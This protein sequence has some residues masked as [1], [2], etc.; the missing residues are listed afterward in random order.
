MSDEAA[1]SLG[2]TLCQNTNLVELNIGCNNLQQTGAINLIKGITLTAVKTLNIAYNVI[3]EIP[4]HYLASPKSNARE[5]VNLNLSGNDLKSVKFF[6]MPNLTKFNCSHI[7]INKE[8]AKDISKFLSNCIN[9]QDLDLSYTN[10]QAT[11]GIYE[12][13]ELNVFHLEKVNISGNLIYAHAADVLAIFL[14]DNDKLKEI[15]LSCNNLQESGIKEVLKSICISN[16]TNLNISD[17][18]ITLD[19]E[20]IA[21]ILNNATKLVELDLSCNKFGADSMDCFLYTS[22]IIFENL[23][24]LTIFTNNISNGSTAIALANALTN[25]IKL[26][27]LDL[28]NNNLHAEGVSKIFSTLEVSTLTKFNFS[29]N[30]ITD[31]AADD[32]ATFLSRNKKLEILDL[33]NN[34]LQAS[35]AIKIFRT[36]LLNLTIVNISYNRITS[37][38]ADDIAAFLCHNTNLQV[39]DLSCNDLEELG[40]WNVFKVLHHTSVLFSLNISNSKVIND[41]ADKLPAVLLHNTL[42]QEIDLSYNNLSTSNIV[43]IF[44]GLKNMSNLVTINISH[45]M[46]TDEAAENIATVLS[47]NNKLQLLDLSC[48]C[49]RSKGFVKIFECLKSINYLR[50]LNVSCNEVNVTAANGIASVLSHNPKLEELNLGNNCMQTTDIII[51]FAKMMCNS[52]LRKLYINGNMITDEAADDIAAVLSHNTKLEELDISCNYFKAAGIIKIF[53]GIKYTS[54]LM[55]FSIAHNM[56]GDEGVEYIDVLSNN[57]WLRELNLSHV[58]LENGFMYFNTGNLK[59][60]DCSNNNISKQS[61]KEIFLSLSRCINLQELDLSNTNLQSSGGINKLNKLDTYNLTKFSI[62]GNGVTVHAADIIAILLSKNDELEELD[63]SCNHLQ[64][65]GI[66]NILDSINISNLFS[67]NISDNYVTGDLK[68]IS[69]ILTHAINLVQLDIS[70]NRLR[71]DHMKHL[72]YKTKNIIAQL[73]RLN[74]SGNIINDEG[75]VALADALLENAKLEEL[76]LSDNCL[77]GKSF[78]RIVNGLQISTLIKLVISYN[79]ITD[80]A[81]DDIASFLSRNTNLQELDLSNNNLK[82]PGTITICKVHLSNLTAFN[83]SHN[84]ITNEA[85]DDIAAFLSHNTKLQVLDISCNNLQELGYRKIFKVLQSVSVLTSLKISDSNGISEAADGLVTVLLHN[86]DLRKLD[87]NCN[88]LSSTDAIT[89]FEGMKEI[90]K[91]ELIDIDNNM[92]TDDAANSVATAL[93]NNSN[94]QILSMSSNCLTSKGCINIFNGMKNILFLRKLNISHNKITYE[95]AVNIATVLSQNTELEELDIS[96]NNLQTPGAITI[97]QSIKTLIKLNIAHNMIT[98]EAVDDIAAVLSDSTK[99]EE[100]D[101]S[102]N[103]L[104]AEGVIKIFQ[105]IKYVLSLTKLNIA[106]NMFGDEGLNF[107]DVL[108]SKCTLREL[109]LNHV[110]LNDVVGFKHLNADNLNM[111]DCSNNNINKQTANEILVFLSHSTNLQELNL[112]NINLQSTGGIHK[113]NEL[114]IYNLTKFSISGNGVTVH[115]ADNIAVLLSKNDELEELD[116]SCNLLQELGIRNILDS[117]NILKLCSLKIS[118]N[119]VTNDSKYISEI[120]TQAINLVELDI[121]YNSLGADH[122]KYFFYKAKHIFAN[123]IRLN[124]S[125]N[126]INDEGAVALNEALLENTKLEELILSENNL[127]TKGIYKIFNALQISTLIKFVISNNDITGKVVDDIASFLSRNTKLQELDLSNNNLKAPGTIMICKIHLS[128]LTAFNISH[129][130]ITIEAADDIAT[131]LSHNTKL[132]ALDISCNNLQEFGY[133]KV[134]KVLQ[135]VSVLTSLKISDSNG[136][137][138]AADGLA[139]VLLHNPDLRELD[140]NCNHLSSTD[141][142]TIFEG[143]K[144]VAKLELSTD[145]NMITDYAVN[146]VATALSNN[147]NLQILSMSSNC[148]TAKDCINIFN[149]M[150]NILFLRKLNISHNKITYE[151]AANIATV[152]SQ[153]TELEELDISYNNLQTPGAVTIFQGLHHTLTLIKLNVAHN[154]ITDEATEC[155][156]HV[157]CNNSNLKELNLS[158][159]SLL[160]RDVIRRIMVSIITKFDDFSEK[161]VLDKLPVI[162]TNL[163]ELDLS[164]IDLHTANAVDIFKKADSISTLTK[165]NI[166]ANSLTPLDAD[167]L[168]NFLSRNN[169]LQEL[170]LSHNDLQESGITKILDAVNCSSLTKVNI[171]SNNANLEGIIKILSHTTKL[172]ELDMSNNMISNDTIC[173]SS[174]S[175]YPFVNLIKLNMFG[176]Y[177]EMT[178]ENAAEL[179][180]MF[181]QNT[182]LKEVNLGGNNLN[183][184][185]LRNILGKLNASTLI[186]LYISYNNITDEVAD[187]IANFLSKCLTLQT[188]DLSHNNLQDAGAI[189]ICAATISSLITFGISYNNITIKSADDMASFFSRNAQMETFD[190]SSNGLLELG[191]RNIFKDMEIVQSTRNLSVLNISNTPV[192]NEA[193]DELT[194]VLQDN[195]RLKE[196]DLSS[197]ILLP[198]NAIKIYGAMRNISN[199]TVLNVSDNIITHEVTEKLAAVLVHNTSLEEL[200]LSYNNLLTLD[201]LKIFEGIKYISSLKILKISHNEISDGAA[202]ELAAVLSH[203]NNLQRFDIS[204]NYLSSEGCTKILNGLKNTLHLKRININSNQITCEA[205]DSIATFLSYN[206]KLEE[207]LLNHNNFGKTGLFKESKCTKLTAL[208]ISGNDFTHLAADEIATFLMNSVELEDIDMSSNEFLSDGIAIIFHG[209]NNITKLKRLSIGHNW[210]NFDAADDIAYI[211]SQNVNLQELCLSNNYLQSSGIITLLSGMSNISKITHLDLSSNKITDEAASNIAI[212]L[213]HNKDLKILDLSDNLLQA[214]GVTTICGITNFSLRKLNLA[215]NAIYDEAS[216]AIATFLSQNKLLEQCDLSKNYLQAVG[217]VKIFRAIKNSPNLL[218]LNMSYNKITNEAVNGIAAVLSLVPKLQELDLDSNMFTIKASDYIKKVF[219]KHP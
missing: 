85:A 60:I 132:Q 51:I 7:N 2:A 117:I 195:P 65:L 31:K 147:S 72:F 69:E 170:D 39:V 104:K 190:L 77:H 64:E 152:L 70:Y 131:F 110:N 23:I 10:L 138:E 197:N 62:S 210:I 87:L 124:A 166:S 185:A 29:H 19:L 90:A 163:Q 122:M 142:I 113:L 16:L 55:N 164:N 174:K 52:S 168:A 160:E 27:E 219:I 101:I 167:K 200:D 41:I 123:L 40:F 141:A 179:A 186:K 198:S 12:L 66:R 22:N 126:I 47:H 155:I 5:I 139:T 118:D 86:P 137:R 89:I 180:H 11:G 175:Q 95:A 207:L 84:N 46:I 214:T 67:L 24:K 28:S 68:H 36:N 211:L 48:N 153:N 201:A 204:F 165:F 146:S 18:N 98:D 184:E 53:E 205:A 59:K 121:S 38:A 143:I 107:I 82:A 54:T 133:R 134:F 75:A 102:C 33:S 4:V 44:K 125:G 130:N 106:H 129:N 140:L 216:D 182:E 30:N 135:S 178:D 157:L 192:I 78:G 63:L 209:M 73:I 91:L 191:I 162:I 79:D 58:N 37:E 93:S 181:S 96:Y 208:D 217:A 154:V 176:I 148:L 20:D 215:G 151:A 32:I 213:L 6:N 100:L 17:N 196:L 94:V 76:I 156:I 57:C 116:L 103:Y 1:D 161:T 111:F 14:S 145:N 25:N 97:F 193:V 92:I 119:Y 83:I 49:L 212:F 71:A 81:A 128:N 50:K 127:Q 3:D 105:S 172:I 61:A 158:C 99:L 56:V 202:D 120:L 149:G 144:K 171:S 112:S 8:M 108:S 80:E 173:F 109:N 15:D 9:L 183:S 45:N 42:L 188:I 206:P 159:N 35:G 26:K 218:K 189:K 169:E 136:I 21:I 88:H 34:D 194:N 43:K 114:D 177:H 199:L 13:R 150:K 203:N 74:A 187:D 115:A